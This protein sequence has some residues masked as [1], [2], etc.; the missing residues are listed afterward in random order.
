MIEV[1]VGNKAFSYDNLFPKIWDS[2]INRINSHSV[3]LG[4]DPLLVDRNP[5]I[6]SIAPCTEK[7][8]DKNQADKKP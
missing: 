4:T 5:A 1:E 3:S 6:F 8:S 2:G 7:L